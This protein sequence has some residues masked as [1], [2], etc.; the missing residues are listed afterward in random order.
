MRVRTDPITLDIIQNSLAAISDEMFVSM[1]RAAMSSVIYEVLDFGVAITDG[2]GN[3]ASAGAG[4]PGFVSMLAPAVRAIIEKYRHKGIN[5]GDVFIANDPFVGGVSHA[6][7]VVLAK[8]VFFAEQVVAWAANKGHWVDIGGMVPGSMSP[9][10]TELFQEGLIIPELKLFEEGRQVEAIFDLIRAN[11]RLPH[12][13]I[14][15]LWAGIAAL[16]VG[17]QRLLD[18]CRKYGA[19]TLLEAIRL[20]LDYGETVARCGLARLPK[21]R[22]EGADTLDDG[23]RIKAVITITD[24]EMIIDLRDNPEQDRGPINGTREATL[25]SAQAVFKAI[26]APDFWANAGSFRPLKL[27]TS[28]GTIFDARRPAAV[29]LYYE[30]KIRSTDLICKTLAPYMPDRIP[31][32]HFASICSTVIRSLSPGRDEKTFVEPEI[33]GWGADLNRDGDNAQ[34]SV[35]HG[36]TFNCPVEVNET[37][38]GI[39]VDRYALNPE[40]SG[41]GKFR[42]GKGI[43]LHY[44]IIEEQGW[45]TAGYTRSV[46]PPWGIAGGGEGTVNRLEVERAGGELEAHNNVSNLELAKDDVV[47][48]TTGNGGGY[49]DP[50]ERNG[51]AIRNDLRNGYVTVNEAVEIYEMDPEVAA[52]N[53]GYNSRS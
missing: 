53:L 35:S 40:P 36:D 12:Q 7:D 15:D 29:S 5:P 37:R 31:A 20:Y 33:G 45:V 27:L 10:A 50:G 39:R 11:S 34:F 46:I 13:A 8:P 26:T 22:F 48:I 52:K 30:N 49:G 18:L 41:A 6:N 16:R 14:G 42:G 21:G 9:G 19:E 2:D 4:I 47:R 25:V 3:L 32:G 23:R 38:N 51:N 44:R 1:A 17:E 28:P 43:E 24:N